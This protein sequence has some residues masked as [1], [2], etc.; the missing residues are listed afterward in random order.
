[1]AAI[2]LNLTIEQGVDYDVTFTVRNKD[3]S[4]LNLLGYSA[5]SK[6]RKHYSST[7]SYPF[8]ITFVDRANGRLALSMS[9]SL[10]S[11]LSEGRYVYDVIIINNS[12]GVKKRVVM[13]SVLV[14]PG[15]SY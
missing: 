4:P 12:T 14:S 3:K 5:E 1:M 10:T 9:D 2:P 11:T 15:V 8:T 7:T 6:I 13:G